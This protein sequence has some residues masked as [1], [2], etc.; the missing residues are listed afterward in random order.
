MSHKYKGC[1][2]L[3]CLF[4]A[5]ILCFFHCCSSNSFRNRLLV[6][7]GLG[8]FASNL[9]QE[10]LSNHDFLKLIRILISSGFQLVI[11]CAM[12]QMS[13]LDNEILNPIIYRTLQRLLHVINLLTIACLYMVDNNLCSKRS[14]DRPVWE[15]L[16]QFLLDSANILCTAF[17]EGCAETYN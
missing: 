5:A 4:Q 7:I 6:L 12:H 11:L 13:G 1:S 9:S 10:R 14:S 16:L 2:V 15:T 3:R 8:A 17:I